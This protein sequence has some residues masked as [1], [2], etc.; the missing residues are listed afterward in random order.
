MEPK[1]QRPNSIRPQGQR[2]FQASDPRYN[3]V[4]ARTASATSHLPPAPFPHSQ[5]EIK[6]SEQQPQTAP[7]VQPPVPHTQQQQQQ[8]APQPPQIQ[9]P[10]S[11]R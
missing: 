11:T 4:D 5:H 10:Q 2:A 1:P 8:Q 9:P 3:L 7:Q 6:G